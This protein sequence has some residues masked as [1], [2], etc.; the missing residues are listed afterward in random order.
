MGAKK[1]F[2]VGAQLSRARLKSL[3]ANVDLAPIGEAGTLREADRVLRNTLLEAEHADILADILLVDI[4]GRFAGD[5][6]EMFRALRARQPLTKVIVLG[7]P[8]SLVQLWQAYPV[9]I[10]GYLLHTMPPAALR[11]ALDLIMS[12]QQILPPCSPA[13]KPA[14]RPISRMPAHVSTTNGLSA[15]EMQI[16]QLLVA[17]SSN[18]AIARDLTI[19][20][21][22]VKVHIR[23]LLR[24]LKA[25]N[26]TQAAL[27]GLQ[28]GFRQMGCLLGLLFSVREFTNL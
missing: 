24:K 26:R 6:P 17:G 22:T 15:R 1:I 14:A 7:D 3:L 21:E 9:G 10:D 13:T 2:F 27:W 12:G 25:S 16:L 20:H 5:E 19:S 23:A 4:H 28:H 8:V 18:K 11:H